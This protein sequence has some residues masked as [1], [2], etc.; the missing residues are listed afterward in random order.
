MFSMP[1]SMRTEACFALATAAS[2]RVLECTS[3]KG[4]NRILSLAVLC[5][6]LSRLLSPSQLENRWYDHLLI[7]D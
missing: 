3:F 5:R 6:S 7:M 2:H 4:T 1:Q